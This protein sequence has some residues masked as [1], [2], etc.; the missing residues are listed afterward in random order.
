MPTRVTCLANSWARH[1]DRLGSTDQQHRARVGP[2]PSRQ[3]SA[4]ARGG[5]RG[6][7]APSRKQAGRSHRGAAGEVCKR[8]KATRRG[9]DFCCREDNVHS[10]LVSVSA[11]TV[12]I[13]NATMTVQGRYCGRPLRPHSRT[14]ARHP[15]RRDVPAACSPTHRPRP[16]RD[17]KNETFNS[18][19]LINQ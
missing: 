17:G 19:S 18:G 6:G 8:R 14:A 5:P 16:C 12:P 7:A 9:P 3:P 1:I 11:R 15:I 10:G 2:A 13:L 4:V